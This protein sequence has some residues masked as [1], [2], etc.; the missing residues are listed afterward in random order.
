[1]FKIALKNVLARKGRL[2]LSSLA[3][4]AGCAFLSGVFVFRDTINDRISKVFAT[5][6]D[7]TDAYVRSAVKIENDFGDDQ[8][9][10]I[11]ESLIEQVRA[12]PGVQA[13]DGDVRGTAIITNPAG[14]IVGGEGPPQFGGVFAGEASSP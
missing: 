3:V 12:V 7:H 8:R 11:D 10:T 13:A 9:G 5:A 2:L 4:I 14:D 1:M 6:Y